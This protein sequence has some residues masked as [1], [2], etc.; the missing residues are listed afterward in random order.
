MS[1]VLRHQIQREAVNV[2]YRNRFKAFTTSSDDVNHH[3]DL[4]HQQ[5]Q[6]SGKVVAATSAAVAGIPMIRLV[7]K[8]IAYNPTVA[9]TS[10]LPNLFYLQ[11]QLGK[12]MF[13]TDKLNPTPH[14]PLRWPLNNNLRTTMMMTRFVPVNDIQL[15]DFQ[16]E[17]LDENP[18]DDDTQQHQQL[19]SSSLVGRGSITIENALGVNMGREMH[20]EVS[21]YNHHHQQ[22]LPQQQLT[23]QS[24]DQQL[25]EQL[26]EV[27]KVKVGSVSVTLILDTDKAVSE[28]SADPINLETFEINLKKSPVVQIDM[29]LDHVMSDAGTTDERSKNTNDQPS[30]YSD[31]YSSNDQSVRERIVGGTNQPSTTTATTTV[32]VT[33]TRSNGNNVLK[34]NSSQNNSARAQAGL[35]ASSDAGDRVYSLRSLVRYVC[36]NECVHCSELI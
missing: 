8:E 18:L 2:A 20:Y 24:E 26:E 27:K 30:E 5:Q 22:Q 11:I 14:G 33:H 31:Y 1:D 10:I 34:D 19:V 28:L 3:H 23:Q 16:I 9:F 35:N 6:S 25:P 15:L 13:V 7:V 29:T 17:L 32:L 21:I 4:R 36:M 12:C